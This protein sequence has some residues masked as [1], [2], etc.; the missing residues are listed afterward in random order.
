MRVVVVGPTG[1]IGRALATALVARGDS[2]VALSRSGTAGI[3]GALDMQWDPAQ[4]PPPSAALEGADALVNLAGVPIGGRRWTA[5]RKRAIHESRTLSTRLLVDALAHDGAP[6]VLVNA[7]AVGFYGPSE[8]EVDETSP[9]GSDFLAETCIAWEREAARATEHGARVVMVRTGIVLARDGGALPQMALPVKLFA[10]GPIGGGRQW[11]PWIHLD[12]EVGVLLLALDDAGVSG[13][14]NASAPEPVRQ[15]DFVSALGRV[16][17]RPS[18][19]PTPAFPLRIA[20]GE[21]ATLA[22]DGQRAVPSAALAAGHA[23]MFS[24]VE[25]ALRAIYS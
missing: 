9:A 14:L 7:S 21:M 2:V 17:G 18:I 13:P 23:F 22:L 11:L 6:R 4:G 25:P 20:M 16:L 1:L 19:L 24:E 5:E 15:R 10:G 12:D 3:D 8:D